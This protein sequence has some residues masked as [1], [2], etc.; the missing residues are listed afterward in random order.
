[1]CGCG[2]R[3]NTPL[4]CPQRPSW[5]GSGKAPIQEGDGGGCPQDAAGSPWTVGEQAWLSSSHLQFFS[6]L[7]CLFLGLSTVQDVS[8]EILSSRGRKNLLKIEALCSVVL[9]SAS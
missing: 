4:G 8:P 3:G 7:K 2:T 5:W 6:S 1:M 9:Y